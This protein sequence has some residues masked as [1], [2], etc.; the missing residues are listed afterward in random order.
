MKILSII[1]SFAAGGAEILVSDLSGA[2]VDSGHAST[3]V[4]LS[5]AEAIGNDVSTEQALRNKIIAGGG[6][7]LLLGIPDR[8]DL[9][10]GARAMRRLIAAERPDVIHAHTARALSMLW[11][12]GARC[13]IVLTHHNSKLSFPPWMFRLFDQIVD[14]YVAIS[15]E[16][17]EMFSARVRRPV[18]HILNAA[19]PGFLASSARTATGRPP[20]LLAVGALTDQKN[21]AMMIEAARRLS[22]AE[23]FRLKIAGNGALREQLQQQIDSGGLGDIVELLGDRHDIPRLMREADLFLNTSHYEGLSIAMVEALQSALPIV[24]TDVQGTREVVKDGGNGLLVPPGDA[25]KYADA[26]VA[27]LADPQAYCRMSEAALVEGTKYRLDD[28]TA[29]H[30]ALY[31]ESTRRAR[32]RGLA[33][34]RFPEWRPR[35]IFR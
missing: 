30:L 22:L 34:G 32:S 4:A 28:C 20:I 19:G 24:A 15:R 1:T 5:P 12:A 27:V 31:G 23:G 10:A 2:F 14:G 26:I 16:C 21:Y 18:T 33:R 9:L 25:G 29:E 6:Q 35:S 7:A 11:L 13:P 3:V 17:F 8:R